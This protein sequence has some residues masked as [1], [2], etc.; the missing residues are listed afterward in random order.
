M[1]RKQ[2]TGRARERTSEEDAEGAGDAAREPERR[3]WRDGGGRALG[4]ARQHCKDMS[5]AIS[6]GAGAGDAVASG[7]A[8]P[9]GKVR[10]D[11]ATSL[12]RAAEHGD[13]GRLKMLLDAGL[14]LARCISLTN[15]LG[16]GHP[17]KF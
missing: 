4:T 2:C 7:E 14:N 16:T 15:T 12:W 11:S 10:I 5:V 8:P 17:H 9:Q 3:D 1:G 13:L 6:V